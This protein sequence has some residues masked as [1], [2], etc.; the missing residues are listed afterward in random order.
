MH[1]HMCMPT[2]HETRS[3]VSW[4]NLML[5]MGEI[6]SK[7]WEGHNGASEMHGVRTFQAH[8]LEP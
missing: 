7:V 8:A 4:H 2:R 6:I 1:W 3:H 5:C